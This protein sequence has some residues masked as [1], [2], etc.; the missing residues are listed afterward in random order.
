[1]IKKYWKILIIILGIF[2]LFL[3]P[4]TFWAEEGS[5]TIGVQV[6]EIIPWMD[7]SGTIWGKK[8]WDSCSPGTPNCVTECQVPKGSWG[9]LQLMG[10]LIK[11][12]TFI[13]WL[14]WVLWIVI[15]GIL[16]SMSG[17]EWSA[18][19]EIKK[20]ISWTLIGLILL[21]LS[22]VILNVVAPWVYK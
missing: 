9:I 22:W 21:L 3:T 10:I 5:K 17:L 8:E 6:T 4:Y 11:Y 15:N 12:F 20:K 16:L 2:S 19:W 18:K 1:M 13:A 7:C 14:G